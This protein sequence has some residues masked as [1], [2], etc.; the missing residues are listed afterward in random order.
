M[1]TWKD[2]R[3]LITGICG[4]VGRELLR[5][6]IAH[7]PS[8]IIG[9]DNNESALFFLEEEYRNRANIH[10]FLG[11]VRDRDMLTRQMKNVDIVLHTAALKHVWLCEKSPTDAVQTNIL[12]VQNVIDA[13]TANQV[14]RVI[15]TSTDKAVNPTSV[16]GTA[17]L[18]GERLMTAANAHGRDEGPIFACTRFGNVLG[19]R[20]SVIPLFK[21]QIAQGGPVTLTDE[22]MSRFMMT[23]SEA[24]RLV[25]E[26][27][28]LAQGGE[29]FVTKMPIVRIVD[30]A[31]VMIEALAPKYGFNPGQIDI[32]VI[33]NRPGEKLYE[34]LIN[35]EESRR[36]FELPNYFVVIPALKSLYKTITY[37]Y[38]NMIDRDE[39]LP[40]NSSLDQAM[41]KADLH[42]YMSKHHLLEGN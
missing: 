39:Q 38:P 4:T 12:G 7:E 11:E 28:F 24:V 8:E 42:T 26:S 25:M 15:F 31:E 27:V 18:M 23:L 14:E 21:Q 16:M 6:V 40:Y 20:G 22:N 32:E 9:I 36:V 5:Q 33:G 2:S 30:L 34:E 37:Q 1:S 35:E 13:A 3:I 17:K 29:V 41:S 10:L 19:S